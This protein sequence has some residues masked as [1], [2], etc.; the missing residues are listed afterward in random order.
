MD[1][2]GSSWPVFIGL[3]VILFG[4]AAFMTGNAIAET[5]RPAWQIIPYG[6]L[7]GA[8]N[9]FLVYALFGGDLLSISGYLVDTIVLLAIA[10]LAFRLTRAHKLVCQYP[11]VYERSGIFSWK[12]KI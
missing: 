11:W 2:L 12:E 1:M 4:F 6:F 8:A 10:A 7:L 3:T 5:W 9:R